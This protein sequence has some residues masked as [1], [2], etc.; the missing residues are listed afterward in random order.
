MLCKWQARCAARPS[1][2]LRSMMSYSTKRNGTSPLPV[3]TP[4]VAGTTWWPRR[5]SWRSALNVNPLPR[6]CILFRPPLSAAFDD[7]HGFGEL[8][9][10]QLAKGFYFELLRKHGVDVFRHALPPVLKRGI[11]KLRLLLVVD[12]RIVN[13]RR[14]RNLGLRRKELFLNRWP[15]R[16]LGDHHDFAFAFWRF[17]LRR[18]LRLTAFHIFDRFL[19]RTREIRR[20][21]CRLQR[22]RPELE[23]LGRRGRSFLDRIPDPAQCDELIGADLR[24]TFHAEHLEHRGFGNSHIGKGLE[25]GFAPRRDFGVV[26]LGYLERFLV[27]RIPKHL[28]H[29]LEHRVAESDAGRGGAGHRDHVVV[30]APAIFPGNAPLDL[31]RD[32]DVGF[33][34]VKHALADYVPVVGANNARRDP[35]VAPVLPD[36]LGEPHRGAFNDFDFALFRFPRKLVVHLLRGLLRVADHLERAGLEIFQAARIS[37]GRGNL[38]IDL[39]LAE[40]EQIRRRLTEFEHLFGHSFS[41]SHRQE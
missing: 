30:V 31:E 38:Q 40:R 34:V 14:R 10:A 16:F 1:S 28:R 15:E 24:N 8:R 32:C 12:Q 21:G 27:E 20:F 11:Q 17:V 36:D 39:G 5:Y 23:S 6:C 9:I 18:D 29:A 26:W 22:F 19:K 7:D 35:A 41:L 25:R 4:V 33:K 37:F 2:P 3:S 13:R